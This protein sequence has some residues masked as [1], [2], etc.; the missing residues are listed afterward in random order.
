MDPQVPAATLLVRGEGDIIAERVEN[1]IQILPTE[2]LVDLGLRV[3]EYRQGEQ[4]IE[5][6]FIRD[7]EHCFETIG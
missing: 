2:H 5:Q 4:A 1:P 3:F 6:E 7:S